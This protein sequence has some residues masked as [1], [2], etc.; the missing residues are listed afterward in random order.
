MSDVTSRTTRG[1]AI[2][3]QGRP[4]AEAGH[5]RREG[6]PTWPDRRLADLLQIEHSIVLASMAGLGTVEL[7]ASVCM[8]GAW[9]RSAA[10]RCHLRSRGKPLRGCER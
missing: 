10:R 9:A 2:P 7:A 1:G 6:L 8:A 3:E 5:P 4:A